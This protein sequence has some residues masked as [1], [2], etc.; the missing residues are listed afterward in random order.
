M[1]LIGNVN[2]DIG[3]VG[4]WIFDSNDEQALFL[5]RKSLYLICS[6]SVGE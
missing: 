6:L 3:I 2:N 1:E 4:Y 5:K